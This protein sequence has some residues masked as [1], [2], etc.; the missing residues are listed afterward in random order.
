MSNTFSV[1]N[2]NEGPSINESANSQCFRMGVGGSEVKA[3]VFWLQKK[4][5][6]YLTQD[7][8]LPPWTLFLSPL[9]CSCL[10]S[11]VLQDTFKN[12]SR[13]RYDT[14]RKKVSRYKILLQMYLDTRYFWIFILFLK[15]IKSILILKED[16]K[17][18]HKQVK[19]NFYWFL[20]N[21]QITMT[22]L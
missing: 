9:Y 11:R 7:F 6:W 10:L 12:V 5:N 1:N 16:W 3:L 4:R 17:I 8:F 20:E 15:K 2:V 22:H 14:F 21:N 18:E 13:Y 19:T